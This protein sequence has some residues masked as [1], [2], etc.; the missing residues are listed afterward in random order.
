MN[1]TDSMDAPQDG[2]LSQGQGL[3]PPPPQHQPETQRGDADD[4]FDYGA[5]D[6][7]QPLTPPEAP[8]GLSSEAFARA[9][10]PNTDIQA[11]AFRCVCVLLRDSMNLHRA[12]RWWYIHRV[13]R[14]AREIAVARCHTHTTSRASPAGGALTASH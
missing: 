8:I 2:S 10:G 7:A 6:D 1:W 4:I 9:S 5:D 11:Q 12:S 13:S 14:R 3:N